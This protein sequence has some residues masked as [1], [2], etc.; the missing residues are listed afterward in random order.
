MKIFHRSVVHA[1]KFG[2]QKESSIQIYWVESNIF[3]NGQSTNKHC[4][5]YLKVTYPSYDME[6]KS[7]AYIASMLEEYT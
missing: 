1:S 2:F 4:D 3:Q 5:S 6:M 7:Y